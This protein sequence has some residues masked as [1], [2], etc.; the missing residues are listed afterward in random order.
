MGIAIEPTPAWFSA[1]VPRV[2][3]SNAVRAAGTSVDHS[4]RAAGLPFSAAS[5]CVPPDA[6]VSE[7]SGAGN[8][9]YSQVASGADAGGGTAGAVPA[10]DRG[11]NGSVLTS[12]PSTILT[13]VLIGTSVN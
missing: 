9:S 12:L 8:G 5:D 13:R 10:P 4:S 2:N 7:K 6:S 3:A 11:W 1:G